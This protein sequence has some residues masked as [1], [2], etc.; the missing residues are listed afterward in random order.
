MRPEQPAIDA[1]IAAPVIR[2]MWCD[3]FDADLPKVVPDAA[4]MLGELS[5]LR[6]FTY[7]TKYGDTLNHP[8]T[9]ND[10]LG[11]I[12]FFGFDDPC[13]PE[14]YYTSHEIVE[15]SLWEAVRDGWVHSL[16]ILIERRPVWDAQILSRDFELLMQVT[17]DERL[18]DARE[19]DRAVNDVL[20]SLGFMTDRI[21]QL[22]RDQKRT[23][24]FIVQP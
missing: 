11:S 13:K 9:W 18:C 5:N 4:G 15:C 6:L 14:Q 2:R 24:S 17:R 23:P 3:D 10:T 7:A 1:V 16:A 22:L 19:I 21:R 12:A 20:A 8:S